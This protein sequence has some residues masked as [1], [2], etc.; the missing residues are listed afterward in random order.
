M[1]SLIIEGEKPPPY[2]PPRTPLDEKDT[3]P[4]QKQRTVPLPG[5]PDG[6]IVLGGPINI[7]TY[8]ADSKKASHADKVAVLRDQMDQHTP[9]PPAP[10]RNTRPSG[11]VRR[12][13][14]NARPSANNNAR[15]DETDSDSDADETAKDSLESRVIGARKVEYDDEDEPLIDLED[16]DEEEVNQHEVSSI[17]DL[18]NFHAYSCAQFSNIIFLLF[19]GDTSHC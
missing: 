4:I 10:F 15:E 16:I 1:L 13:N 3:R 11:K 7:L 19:E 14:R 18:L 5:H 6:N 2:A 12:V 9:L 17:Q 8:N